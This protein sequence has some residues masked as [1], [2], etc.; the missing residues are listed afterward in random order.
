[1]ASYQ[2]LKQHTKPRY[3]SPAKVFAKLKSKVQRQMCAGERI[4]ATSD[5]LNKVS[6]GG[7]QFRSPT[8][9]TA[10]NSSIADEL[11]ENERFGSYPHEMQPLTLSPISSPQKDFGYSYSDHISKPAGLFYPMINRGHGHTPG[12]RT[13][14]ESTEMFEPHFSV[15]RKQTHTEPISSRDLDDFNVNSMTNI[16]PMLQENNSTKPSASVFSPMKKRLRKRKGDLNVSYLAKQVCSDGRH[17]QESVFIQ[18]DTHHNSCLED[19]VHNRG[20]SAVHF[21]PPPSAAKKCCVIALEKIPPISPAKMF[22]YMKE[23]ER[24]KEQQEVH[25]IRSSTTAFQDRGNF[26]QSKNAPADHNMDEA[27]R[28]ASVPET[29]VPFNWS[30]VEPPNSQSDTGLSE[31]VVTPDVP[32]QPVLLED[33]L[34]L[35]TPRI[36][37]PKKNESVFKRDKGL[38][39]IKFP[40]ES[41]IYLTKWYLMKATKGLYVE[42]IHREEGIPWNSNI[43][44]DRVSNRVLKTV[45]GRV[46]ILVGKM[47]LRVENGLPQWLLK[48]FVTGFPP[49]WKMIYEKF[50]SE[51]KNKETTR[52]R[53]RGATAKTKSEA[54]IKH[55]IKQHRKN[56]VKTPESCRPASS[57]STTVSRSGRVIKPPLEYWK[58]GRVIVD[59]QMN[60]TIHECYETSVLQPE[61]ITA[62]SARASRKPT[63][64]YQASSEGLKQC[65]KASNKEATVPQRKVKAPLQRHNKSKVS[66][67]SRS[68]HSPQTSTD[69]S[70]SAEKFSDKEARS[71]QKYFAAPQKQSKP[72][73]YSTRSTTR[74]EHE[75]TKSSLRLS[76]SPESPLSKKTSQ[77]KLSNDDLSIHRKKQ[78]RRV[79]RDKGDRLQPSHM[80][81]ESERNLRKTK[82]RDAAQIP[83]KAKQSKCTETAQPPKPS[84]KSA[85]PTTKHKGNTLIPQEQDEDKWTEAEIMKLKEAVAFYPK[86]MTGYWAKVARF[87][88]TR[89]AEECHSQHTSQETSKTPAKGGRKPKKKYVE[90][91]KHPDHPVISARV[92]TLKRKQQ[93]RQ[94]LETMP[95]ENVDD[96]FNSEYMQNKRFEIPSMCP[97]E[98]RDFTLT[99]LEP[100]T[101]MS[102]GLP[103]SKTP[104]CLHI[105]PG[106]MGCANRSND[107]KYVYQLQKRM[108]KSQFN[109]KQAP[110][111]KN[112]SPTPSVKRSLRRCVNTEND[113][114]LVWEM[115]PGN[116]GVLS[117]SGEEEDFYFSD[118]N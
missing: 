79:H 101:P 63:F 37:I 18:D 95:R 117:D 62:V 112:F 42:G 25:D 113:N 77:D 39:S 47:V 56:S 27:E 33:P 28:S 5:A 73:K 1:M 29:V 100:T 94:F 86:H 115:F 80:S 54:S 91:P 10:D 82:I 49:N 71:R 30:Q 107:D 32:P 4:F 45:S 55:S 41:V 83:R 98:D 96:V 14:L 116:N 51:S 65:D 26:H 44:M 53:S 93:V 6:G 118:N 111:S 58:G 97:S 48:K 66:H 69:S 59:A 92:G 75:K 89:S 21:P 38:Q 103:E 88:G 110:S 9:R 7:A 35:N 104:Q 114:F 12:K 19:L 74:R 40:S 15:I 31:E 72:E 8:K 105:T 34:I 23:R 102:I 22:A 99:D 13:N 81:E 36:S 68:S 60:V 85:Q 16:Q 61:V 76:A 2:H 84:C 52:N 90:A 11:K 50:L 78:G 67:E 57:S 109:C 46:Y 70:N 43:I 3:E 87:V 20:T 24:R 106:M 108:K 64:V 17:V